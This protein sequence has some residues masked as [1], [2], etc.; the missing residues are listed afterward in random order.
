MLHPERAEAEKIK[1][2]KSDWLLSKKDIDWQTSTI[3]QS[4]LYIPL[5]L[6]RPI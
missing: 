3:P 6:Y 1:A 5:P 2:K 4:R